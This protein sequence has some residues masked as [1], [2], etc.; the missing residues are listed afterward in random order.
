M[1]NLKAGDG[2]Q[3]YNFQF[4]DSRDILIEVGQPRIRDVS[5]LIHS[6][7]FHYGRRLSEHAAEKAHEDM[8]SD[9]VK[10]PNQDPKPE[11][12]PLPISNFEERCP[13]RLRSLLPP[14]NFGAVT[15]G[16]I[17]R[18]SYPQ[19]DN[20]EFL[21]SLNLKTILTLVPEEI[22]PAYRSFMAENSIQHFQHH[23]PANKGRIQ[24]QTCQM[25]KILNIV[26]DR[27]NHPML[28]HCNKG[29]HRTGCV[30]GCFRKVQAEPLDTIFGEYHT[31]ADPKARILDEC[32][33]EIFDDRTVLWMARKH[34][35]IP[36]YPENA[37]P[38]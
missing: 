10:A 35:W 32:F 24:V 1:D 7:G 22:S 9:A 18:S 29:K 3:P 20:F 34:N 13:D 25:T 17:Y 11:L 28:I 8:P 14:A 23:I 4:P 37:P 33:I 27:A 6:C 21:K 16:S 38:C 36:P 31:Y 2:A 12:I 26:L 15:P 30:V 19:P 5:G